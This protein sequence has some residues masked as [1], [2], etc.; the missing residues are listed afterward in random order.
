M[1]NDSIKKINAS[2]NEEEQY[3]LLVN[4]YQLNKLKLEDIK[5]YK[6]YKLRFNESSLNRLA[7][8]INDDKND[9]FFGGKEAANEIYKIA[10]ELGSSWAKYRYAVNILDKESLNLLDIEEAIGLL[11]KANK[12]DNSIQTSYQLGHAYFLLKNYKLVYKHFSLLSEEE[13]SRKIDTYY[14]KYI[15]PVNNA[16]LENFSTLYKKL[17]SIDEENV[18]KFL[19]EE[20]NSKKNGGGALLSENKRQCQSIQHFFSSRRTTEGSTFHVATELQAN[21]SANKGATLK[22]I[23]VTGIPT[24]RLITAELS[25]IE[26]NFDF[27]GRNYDVNKLLKN[28]SWTIDYTDYK[29]RNGKQYKK[30]YGHLETVN[31]GGS[32]IQYRH[33]IDAHQNQIGDYVMINLGTCEHI[34]K[35]LYDLTLISI[36]KNKKSV[37][38]KDKEKEKKLAQWMLR[39][40]KNGTP[41]TLNELRELKI[42]AS[43]KQLNDLHHI[44]YHCFV[45]EVVRWMNPLDTA[46]ELPFAIAQA[47]AIKLIAEGHLSLQDVFKQNVPYGIF[48]GTYNGINIRPVERKIKAINKLYFKKILQY[49]D[50]DDTTDKVE[51]FREQQSQAPVIATRSQLHNELSAFYGGGDDTDD[52]GYDSDT[53][54][55]LYPNLKKLSI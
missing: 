28:I 3:Q 41:V 27:L 44:F 50:K 32:V 40:A 49:H 25:T 22:I 4:L 53:A 11:Q 38:K 8:A 1:D 42:T 34:F 19:F 18:N 20:D 7:L 39:Y 54:E 5:S 21:R 36:K 37:K 46:N 14:D 10:I 45:K 13:K 51:Q 33:R 17:F 43:Q 12:E 15:I 24:R 35:K 9:D 52:E 16:L 31:L 55:A 2:Q 47:R 23:D 29:R 26:T 48:N 6:E 30:H